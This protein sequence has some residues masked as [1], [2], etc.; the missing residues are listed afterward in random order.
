MNKT[1]RKIMML[2]LTV[3]LA[4]SVNASAAIFVVNTTAD[5][6][7]AVAGD[8]ICADSGGACSLRAA[9]TEANALAGAD[10][11]TLPVG[12]YTTTLPTTGR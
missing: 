12:T 5:T 1:I 6:Q 10:I 11:I 7:D 2:V 4:F 3:T 9:I 8:G